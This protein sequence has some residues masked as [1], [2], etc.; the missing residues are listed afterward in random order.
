MKKTSPISIILL[1]C[2]TICLSM[3][4]CNSKDNL[5]GSWTYESQTYTFSEDTFISDGYVY[6]D[7]SG[8]LFGGGYGGGTYT[9]TD[10]TIYFYYDYFDDHEW[11]ETLEYSFEI[12]DE[13]HIK[14]GRYVFEKNS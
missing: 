11:N 10:D 13:T 7:K 6:T 8:S 14:I 12:I 9:V 4:S 5:S 3:V 1:F 2:M